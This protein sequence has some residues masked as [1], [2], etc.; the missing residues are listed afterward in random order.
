MSAARPRRTFIEPRELPALLRGALAGD[1][2]A[3]RRIL[4]GRRGGR[5]GFTLLLLA[6]LAA[7]PLG[8]IPLLAAAFVVLGAL[9]WLVQRPSRRLALREVLRAGLWT[10]FPFALACVPLRFFVEGVL[11]LLVAA[12]IGYGLLWLWLGRGLED[13]TPG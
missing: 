5:Y 7:A 10:V 9:T 8:E 11:P 4:G 13:S 12:A 1:P 2:R 6:G 3:L